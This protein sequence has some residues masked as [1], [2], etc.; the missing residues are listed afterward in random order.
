MTNVVL[1]FRLGAL[2]SKLYPKQ[3]PWLGAEELELAELDSV[4][5]EVVGSEGKKKATAG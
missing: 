4:V 3:W 2:E 5:R 1:T